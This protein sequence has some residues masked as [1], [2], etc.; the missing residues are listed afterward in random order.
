MISLE[1]NDHFMPRPVLFNPWKHHQV[2]IIGQIRKFVDLNE[3]HSLG[4]FL[5]KIGD[6]TTDLYVGNLNLDDIANITLEILERLNFRNEESYL[7]WIKESEG[8]YRTEPFPDGS[9]WV[10][11]IGYDEGRHVHIHPGRN[12]PQTVRVKAN[13]LKTAIS[14]NARALADGV[15]PLDIEIINSVRREMIGIDPVR[16]VTM[17]HE[18]GRMIYHFAVKFGILA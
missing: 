10:F 11:K 1:K 3:L 15:N 5:K 17:N 16:F 2:F 18:L 13:V 9:V 14:V 4:L 6:S 12:V 8:E 7:N